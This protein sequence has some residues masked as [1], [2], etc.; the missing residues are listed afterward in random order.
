MDR[1]L[2]EPEIELRGHL[3]RLYCIKYHPYAKNVLASASYDRTI[4]V[5]NIDTRQ[6][7]RTLRGHTDVVSYQK[8]SKKGSCKLFGFWFLNIC[9]LSIVR[10]I[11]N[12]NKLLDEILF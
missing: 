2:E 11:K 12:Y 7:E 3:E 10:K 8:Y 9:P 1:S 5:W 6:A 4:K